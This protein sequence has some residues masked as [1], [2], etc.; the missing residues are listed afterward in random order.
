MQDHFSKHVVAY[1]GKHQKAHTAAKVLRA[2]YFGMIGAPAYLISDQGPSF[3]G[4][5]YGPL[6]TV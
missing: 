6:Q 1:V 3:A 5:M 2:G 4:H